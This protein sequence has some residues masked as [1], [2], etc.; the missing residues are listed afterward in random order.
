VIRDAI[1]TGH[2]ATAWLRGLPDFIIIGAQKGGT[3]SLY[4]YLKEHPCVL[5][6]FG[7]EIHFFDRHHGRG[8]WWYRSH[9][10]LE[11]YKRRHGRA[12]GGVV[13][14]GEASPFYLMHPLVPERAFRA[15][16]QAKLIAL[17]REPVSRAHSH[18]HQE[19]RVG[20]ET[21]SFEEAVE[22]EPQ[23]IAGERD[24][25]MTEPHYRSYPLE[26]FS[27]LTRGVYIDQLLAWRKFYPAGQML[28]LRSEDLFD[29]PAGTYRRVLEFLG[30]PPHE[31]KSA[32]RYNYHG[33]YSAMTPDTRQRLRDYFQPHNRRLCEYL[34]WERAWED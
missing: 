25:L 22:Q 24:R 17:L 7:K 28:V 1:R 14:C 13:L 10:P 12:H 3:T 6:S 32:K 16:P 30:L 23:R 18:H 29:D 21:L 8:L 20:V 15:A 19:L 31:L 9:F 33:D 34:G 4:N 11:S 26:K 27:Y 2:L 5:P